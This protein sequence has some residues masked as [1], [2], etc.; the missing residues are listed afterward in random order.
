[1]S[2]VGYAILLLLLVFVL[3]ISSKVLI[4]VL[5]LITLLLGSLITYQFLK[6]KKQYNN[7]LYNHPSHIP[8]LSDSVNLRGYKKISS[9][10]LLFKSAVSNIELYF[11][12]QNLSIVYP[13][14]SK[15]NYPLDS[16]VQLKRTS[17]KIANTSV[18]SI[19]ISEA[20][21]IIT[22]KFIPNIRLWN[23]DFISFYNFLLQA[24]PTAVKS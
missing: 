4:I 7:T 20:G 6:D 19:S 16:I 3:P 1:M 21:G 15:V 18:W 8:M 24:N 11:N 2:V 22:Y 17:T 10:A 13:N 23:K 14:G 5:S 12:S 9:K